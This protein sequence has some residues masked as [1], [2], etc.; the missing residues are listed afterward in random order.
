MLSTRA[1]GAAKRG[2]RAF[3]SKDI[4]HGP[5]ARAA[6]LSGANRLADAVA[7]TLGPKGRNVVIEQSFGPPKVTKDG[8]SSFEGLALASQGPCCPP[9][10]RAPRSAALAL[11]RPRTSAMVPA[12]EQRCSVAPTAWRTQW[13]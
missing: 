12:P 9:E 3:A 4:R 11:L 8:G 10:P 7:V 1:S 5:S 2:A 6:M 13:R